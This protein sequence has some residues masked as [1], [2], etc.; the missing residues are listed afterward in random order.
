MNYIKHFLLLRKLIFVTKTIWQPARI[1]DYK[2]YFFTP[3]HAKRC[4]DLQLVEHK[5]RLNIL[6]KQ[7][8]RLKSKVQLLED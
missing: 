1:G 4:F 6:R 8:K 2:E 5:K 3:Y 7:I